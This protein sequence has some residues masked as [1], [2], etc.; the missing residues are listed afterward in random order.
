LAPLTDL[1]ANLNIVFLAI[2]G[3]LLLYAGRRRRV[4]DAPHCRSC[5]YLLHGLS[6]ERCPECGSALSS[7]AIIYGEPRRR[8]KSF[9]AGWLVLL[10]LGI[11]V[12]T[13]G[14]S[15]LQSVD[16]YHYKPAHFVLRDLNSGR[17]PDQQRAWTELVRR[18]AATL[19]SAKTR[20]AMARFALTQQANAAQPYNS[21]DTNWVNYLG[22]RCL[23][24]D[25]PA[26]ERTKFFE[27]SIR[28]KLI[29]RSSVVAGD[30]VPYIV[31]HEGL[32]PTTNNFWTRLTSQ[33]I[34]IDGRQIEGPSGGSTSFGGFGIGSWG[35][36]TICP[37]TGK[38]VLGLTIR[39]EIFTDP[40]DLPGASTF[41]YQ[42][43]R[44]LTDNFEVLSVR[45]VNLIRTIFDPKLS[46][47]VKAS[48]SPRDFHYR[49]K[50]HFLDGTIQFTHPPMN[51]A[52]DVIA[53]YG[54][55]EHRL[56]E[57]TY[58]VSPPTG[59]YGISGF[60]TDPPPAR[61][62]LVLRPSEQAAADTVDIYSYWN[63]EMMYPNVPVAQ[64]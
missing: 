7:D 45:P 25:L 27:Q 56:G 1:S 64:Q 32:G 5:N 29:V 4:G 31:S 30:P 15:E 54:G 55:K 23:A 59:G 58:H 39:I 19:L 62:D 61:V 35:T 43:D 13:G 33:S 50:D 49:L 53:L 36:S 63:Q 18:D 44:T 51:L 26:D 11:L 41:R 16:W 14:I 38:H 47:V 24:N 22:V 17:A 34:S 3:S 46:A 6:S 42:T 10:L 8:W 21:M 12:F 52:F 40:M 60:F 57:M 28:T 37:S 48:L 9:L 2:V 20:D